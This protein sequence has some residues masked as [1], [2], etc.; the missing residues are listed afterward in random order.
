MPDARGYLLPNERDILLRRFA[1]VLVLFPEDPDRAPYPDEGDAIYT[2]RGSYHPRTVE[3]FLEFA[4]VRHAFA[5]LLRSP[6]PLQRSRSIT[7]LIEAIRVKITAQDVQ[8]GLERWQHEPQYYGSG[9]DE[10]ADAI[11]TRLLQERLGKCIRGFDLPLPHNKNLMQWKAYYQ[12][13][14]Q[15]AP[16]LR[17]AMVYGRLVQGHATPH[18]HRR[19]V[20]DLLQQPVKYG[21]HDVNRERVALQYWFH[22]VYD[23]WANRHEGDWESITLLLKL[24]PVVMESTDP[25]D[26]TTLVQN[27]IVQEVGYAAHEDGH[28]RLWADV[29][30][31]RDGRPLVYVARGSSAAYFDWQPDGYPASARIGIVEKLATLP[32]YFVRGRRFL[33]RR[34]DARYSARFTGQDA[35]NRD[36]VAADPVPEDRADDSPSNPLEISVPHHCRGARRIPRVEPDAGLGDATYHLETKDLFWLEMV[37]EHGIQWGEDALLPGNKAPGGIKPAV[38]S[39]DRQA[40]WQMALL[41]AL[42]EQII[43]QL[44]GVRYSSA[45]AIPELGPVLL[46]LRPNKLLQA[47][48]FPNGIRSFV[49]AMW[50][51]ILRKHPE[52]WPGGPG[53]RLRWIFARNFYPPF[54]LIFPRR[55]RSN[56]LLMRDD[57]S[58]FIKTLLAQVRQTRYEVQEKGSKWDNPFAWVRH[59]CQADTSFYGNAHGSDSEKLNHLDCADRQM[60]M[61]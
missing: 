31:V 54:L 53:L 48:C 32:G 49:Y 60:L 50:G 10:I 40:I 29:Q 47:K 18:V 36:W 52:A 61:D 30:R 15:V 7:D 57:P 13:L 34:W 33:G 27:T 2:M 46:P 17:R 1:P 8:Q 4:R 22:Y 43:S 45:H 24:S 20:E 51:R 11:R 59:V 35:K 12:N 44:E 25:L 21:P 55:R 16:A 56:P 37:H 41:E 3:F 58:Y 28:R 23:D 9:E 5:H 26:E 14:G 19:S 39:R 38:R 42:I 6:D